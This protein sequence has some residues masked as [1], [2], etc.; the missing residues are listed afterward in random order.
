ERQT[1]QPVEPEVQSKQMALARR[2]MGPARDPDLEARMGQ[3]NLP[4]LVVFGT[5]DTVLA[6]EL[7]RHYKELLPNCSLMFM[8]DAAHEADADRPEAF[9]AL[10]TSSSSATKAF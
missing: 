1:P 5:L 8:Y 7:G 9:A 3:L 4:V 6:P 10:S 2:I